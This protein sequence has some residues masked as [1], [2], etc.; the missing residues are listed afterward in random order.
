MPQG[1]DLDTFLH[2]PLVAHI[3]TAGPTVRPVW[4][5]WEEGAFWWLTGSWAKLPEIIKRDPKIVF[6]I[7]TWDP[8]TGEVLQLSARGKA[9]LHPFDPNRARRKLARYLGGDQSKWDHERFVTGTFDN[10]STAFVK[11]HPERLTVKDL[12]YAPPV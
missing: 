3:A 4:Y 11:L 8:N 5:L 9:E 10:P 2:R 1:F 12:S 7:D 6:L